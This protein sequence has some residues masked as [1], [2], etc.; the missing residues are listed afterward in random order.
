MSVLHLML[1][2]INGRFTIG[3]VESVTLNT[4][5]TVVLINQRFCRGLDPDTPILHHR[6]NPFT[7]N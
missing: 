6:Q 5:F 7:L 4:V 3:T 1:V 2:T